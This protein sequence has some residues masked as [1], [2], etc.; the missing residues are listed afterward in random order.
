MESSDLFD[1]ELNEAEGYWSVTGY[2]GRD[3][4]VVFPSSHKGKPVKVIANGFSPYNKRIKRINIPESYTS[5]GESAF[6]NCTGLTEVK[7]PENLVSIG[8]YVFDG[9]TGLTRINLPE[10][11][12]TVGKYAFWGCIGLTEIKFPESLTSIGDSAFCRCT[13]LAEIILPQG[14]TSLGEMVFGDCTGL[15]KIRFPESLTSI[16]EW[17][18]NSC[19]GLTEINLPENLTSIGGWAFWDCTELREIKFSEGLTAIGD[20]AFRGCFGLTGVNLPRGLTA[21]EGWAFSDCIGLTSVKLPESLTSI[22][23][24]AFDNCTGLTEM[25][26][27][28]NNPVF[29]SLDGVMFDKAMITLMWFPQ[30]KKGVYSVPEGIIRIR[31]GAFDNCKLTSISFPKSLLF[32]GGYEF[33]GE[34]LTDITVNELNPNYCSIDGVLF[35]K[36]NEGLMEYPKNKDKTDYTVPDGTK[37]IAD[38]AF[39]GCKRLVNI[40]FPETLEFILNY[41]FEKCEGLK[42]VTLP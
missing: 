26:M 19:T 36:E 7:L 2:Y 1:F 16:G 39:Y 28:E 31:N 13:G 24:G 15:T 14:L 3:K 35:D 12:T 42:T 27:D 17:A 29:C 33:N 6:Q 8:E 30:G 23:S 4:E 37:G 34:Q 40:V 25:S 5:I 41:A 9:C 11:L 20:S 22:K 21:I 32:I 18:F 38:S 10:K